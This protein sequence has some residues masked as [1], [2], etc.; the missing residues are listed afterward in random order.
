MKAGT[1]KVVK[2]LEGKWCNISA[3][4]RAEL[5]GKGIGI[6]SSQVLVLIDLLIELKVIDPDKLED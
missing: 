5:R 4:D 3:E 2:N 6:R 1:R